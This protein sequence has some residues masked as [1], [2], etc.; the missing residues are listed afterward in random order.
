MEIK[1]ITINSRYHDEA[2]NIFYNWWGKDIK[3]ISLDN[4]VKSYKDKENEKLPVI[5]GIIINDTL[6]GLYEINEKDDIDGEIYT[7]YLA[8]VYVKPS[9]RGQGFGKILILDS[10][11]KLRN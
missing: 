10:L 4:I 9:Y 7:P 8:N 6:I 1:K 3:K 5:Y 11:K 2:V